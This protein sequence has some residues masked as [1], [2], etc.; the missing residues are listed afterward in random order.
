MITMDFQPFS[1]VEDEGFQLLLRVLDRRYQLPSRKYFSEQ[2]IPKMYTELKEKVV[3]V[4]Q[5]AVTLALTTDCW[6]SRSTDFYISITLH[7]IND[8]FKRQLVVLDTFPMCERH[9][10]QN[11]LSKILPILKA[12]AIDKNA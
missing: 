5:S 10:T 1:I 7:F 6:T 8:E 9:T 3:T 11:L 2:V 12:W 4:V